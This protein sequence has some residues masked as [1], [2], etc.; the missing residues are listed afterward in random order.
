MI[1][2]ALDEYRTRARA[3]IK[4]QGA[5]TSLALVLIKPKITE[6]WNNDNNDSPSK[7]SILFIGAN[8]QEK[9]DENLHFSLR[10]S[11]GK[12]FSEESIPA[13]MKKEH[14]NPFENFESRE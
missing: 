5:S 6:E 4:R 10:L 7:L 13:L 1:Q 8:N 3:A 12:V 11:E 2:T 9:D 14:C